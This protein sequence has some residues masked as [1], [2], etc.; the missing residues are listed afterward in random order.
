LGAR[1][2]VFFAFVAFFFFMRSSYFEERRASI[3]P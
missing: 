3:R 1:F 2:A